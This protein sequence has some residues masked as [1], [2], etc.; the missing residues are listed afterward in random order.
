MSR[1]IELQI[2]TI[3]LR[4]KEINKVLNQLEGCVWE[5]IQDQLEKEVLDHNFGDF[6]RIMPPIFSV[7]SVFQSRIFYFIFNCF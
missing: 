1:E 2:K 6:N 7:S 5:I 3:Y 4:L